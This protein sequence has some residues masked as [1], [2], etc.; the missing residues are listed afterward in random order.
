[1]NRTTTRDIQNSSV[2]RALLTGLLLLVAFVSQGCQ[3]AGTELTWQLGDH[4]L[5]MSVTKSPFN[6]RLATYSGG[7]SWVE[8][9]RSEIKVRDPKPRAVIFLHGCTGITGNQQGIISMFLGAGYVVFAPDSFKR[10]GR[11]ST[12][13]HGTA[14]GTPSLRLAEAQYAVQQVRKA[15]WI[16][17][18]KIVLVGFSEGGEAAAH[19][20]GRGYAAV[21]VMSSFCRGTGGTVDAASNVPVLNVVGD[22]DTKY[23]K[24][25]GET[26]T[27]NGHPKSKAVVLED[28]R[29]Q[30]I[31]SR[32]L[33]P[34]VIMFLASVFDK[35]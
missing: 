15:D 12:C 34:T 31:L 11:K 9:G 22:S 14:A 7:D 6:I 33:Q 24:F 4:G 35:P 3:T 23:S 10:P 26:C 29:H 30:L 21:I 28:T 32:D 2:N 8:Q 19:S 25:S 18:S 13:G 16:E 17:Q 5:P 20:S 1:M 27:V